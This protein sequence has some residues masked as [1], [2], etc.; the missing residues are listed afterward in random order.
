MSFDDLP[1]DWPTRAVTDPDVLVNLVDLVVT[2]ASRDE[3]V[4][5]VWLCG[6][7]DRLM[8]PC[9]VTAVSASTPDERRETIDPFARVLA[10]QVPD[11]SLVVVIARP[12]APR[13]T[14]DDELWRDAA[15]TVCRSRRLRLAGVVVATREAIWQL[16]DPGLQAQARS[17]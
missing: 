6:P 15:Q 5:Y 4:L 13:T 12:G 17:A 3:G 1:P 10:E 2:E 16:P 7:A 9:A 8:Q 11:G 14:D